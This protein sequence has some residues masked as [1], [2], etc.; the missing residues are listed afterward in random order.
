MAKVE[1]E[2][3]TADQR[4]GADD[5]DALARS[6]GAPVPAPKQGHFLLRFWRSAV[7]KKW[8]MAVSGIVLLGFVLVHMIGNLKV[9][10]GKEHINTY[11]EWLRTLGEPALPRTVLLWVVRVVLIGA[12]VVHIVAAAQLTRM[13]MKARPVRYQSRRDYVAANF[14]SRTMRWTGIIVGLFVIFHL[15]DLTWG[16]ANPNFVRGD[17]Y[18][19]LFASFERV[20]V[21]I[22]YI[23]AMI[24]LSIHIFH[25]AWSM[26][27]SLGWNNPRWNI[28][29]RWFAA[30]FALVILVGNVSMPL[31]I[32]TGAVS[33]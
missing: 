24:A 8:L 21:A 32:T 10:L 28:W 14:A 3:S 23:V 2:L 18:D 29:R 20:P 11:G 19:N 27:Q 30:L 33:K 16:S 25:G 6:Y 4:A 31:L 26:F 17:V 15:L 9:F 13:N 5:A 7:G 12:F 1:E 22:V